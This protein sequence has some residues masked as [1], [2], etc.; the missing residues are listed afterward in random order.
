[1]QM[2]NGLFFQRTSLKELGLEVHL[3]HAPGR[4]C[5]AAERG[6]KNFLVMH[7]NGMH[8]VSVN[9]CRCSSTADDKPVPHHLQLLRVGWWPATPISPKSCAT[10]TMLQQFHLLNLQGKITAYSYYRG[11]EYLTDSTGLHKPPVRTSTSSS[12]LS[13]NVMLGSLRQIQADGS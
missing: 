6:N 1:M 12:S 8:E 11:L 2:W 10:M 7:T 4:F 13:L 9:F 3:E 5:R